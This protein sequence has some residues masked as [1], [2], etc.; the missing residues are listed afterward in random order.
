M[1][2]ELG[3]ELCLFDWFENVVGIRFIIHGQNR[4]LI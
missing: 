3:L 4:R 2:S 1:L